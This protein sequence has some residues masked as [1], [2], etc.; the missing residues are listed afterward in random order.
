[1][2][3][4]IVAARSPIVRAGLEAIVGAREG[5]VMA[6]SAA[7]PHNA[8]APLDAQE[9]APAD[10]I[11]CALD[12]DADLP[13]LAGLAPLVILA[14]TDPAAVRAL[15]REGVRAVLPSDADAASIVAAIEAAA[16][17][18]IALPA[19]MV[20]DVLASKPSTPAD[21][22][23]LSPRETEVLRMLADGLGNKEIARVLSLS[24]HT[25]KF[26]IAS[27]FTK[28]GVGTRTEAVTEGLRRGMIFL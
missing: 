18:L 28:L 3:R 10:V 5:L 14:E 6:G 15:L 2:I 24:D 4:V 25:I 22:S 16:A 11:L 7:L 8:S 23:V 19:G 27:I 9:T 1:V 20:E 17:G 12:G 13:A 26:H 21:G